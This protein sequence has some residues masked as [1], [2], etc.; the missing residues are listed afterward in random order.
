MKDKNIMQD[1]EQ[2]YFTVNATLK[3]EGI[4][5]VII[6]E[7]LTE[8]ISILTYLVTVGRHPNQ[9]YN[10]FHLICSDN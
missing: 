3:V 1:L 4:L 10:L 5:G 7:W 8:I 6:L 9:R 2:V